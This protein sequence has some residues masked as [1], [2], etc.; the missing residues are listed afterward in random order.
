[1]NAIFGLGLIL[2]FGLLAARLINKI[3]FPSVT[4]Y[5]LLG[6]LIGPSLGNLVSPELLSASGFISNIVLGLIAFSLGQNFTRDFFHRLGRTIIWISVLEAI[7]PW[8]LV[9]LAVYFF[10]GQPFY[11]ALIFGAISSATAPAATVMV[12]RE[13]KSKGRFTDVLLGVV[14]ID[15]AWCLIIFAISLAVAKALAFHMSNGF[16]I[17]VIGRSLFEISGAFMLGGLVAYIA[18]YISKFIR[19][20]TELLIYT[21]GFILFTSGLALNLHFSVL[22]A[23]MFLGAVL[24]NIKHTNFRF[25]EV[26]KSVDTPLYLIFFCLAGANLEIGLLKGIGLVGLVYL[27]CRITGKVVG[28]I[29][30]GRI[31]KVEERIRRYLGWGLLPQ[32]GVALGCALIAK[33]D[34]PQFGGIIFT[35]IVATTVIYELIGP[36]CTKIALEKAGEINLPSQDS[37]VSP[38]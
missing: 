23:N 34:F 20:Q 22:L 25:F 16:L 31:V 36:I 10:A 38:S 24:V 11:V 7:V 33:T 1:M 30:G 35:T 18:S 8:F 9:A 14:A 6:I 37:S 27:I 4:A 21:L 5:L 2:L 32:A 28:S 12:I 3:K 13:Y 17:K 19:T 15:D 26:L 29:L